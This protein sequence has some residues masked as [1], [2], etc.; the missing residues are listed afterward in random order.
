MKQKLTDE[1][2]KVIYNALKYYQMH[3]TSLNGNEYQICDNL[4]TRWFDE[5]HTQQKEQVR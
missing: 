2:K 1:D 5:V 4:L 3:R